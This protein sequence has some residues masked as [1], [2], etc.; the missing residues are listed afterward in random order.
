MSYTLQLNKIHY[1]PASLLCV[2]VCVVVSCAV[3]LFVYVST[4]GTK[5]HKEERSISFIPK[6][7]HTH[8]HSDG[9]RDTIQG[10]HLVISDS[11]NLTPS[12]VINGHPALCPEP[13]LPQLYKTCLRWLC[14]VWRY[15][16]DLG[17]RKSK[18]K[19]KNRIEKK[20]VFIVKQ[21][22]V[23]ARTLP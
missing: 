14:Q 5:K 13:L 18:I 2:I 20:T 3:S 7:A 17:F 11:C 16:S 19:I 15:K 21:A 1:A 10:A 8:S 23:V 22:A 6:C 9:D 4:K 12:L